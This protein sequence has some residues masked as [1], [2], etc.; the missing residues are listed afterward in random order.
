[1][2]TLALLAAAGVASTAT[3]QTLTIDI[4]ADNTQVTGA[5]DT[6]VN[7]DVVVSLSGLADANFGAFADLAFDVALADAGYTFTSFGW[8][9]TAV[10]NGFG[11]SFNL[12][13]TA[14]DGSGITGASA[15]NSPPPGNFTGGP[16]AALSITAY[17]FSIDVT[18][19]SAR[20]FSTGFALSGQTTTAF[21][22]PPFPGIQDWNAS[23]EVIVNDATIEVVPAPAS[24]G[25]L[26]LGGLVAAR[27]RR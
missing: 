22:S 5:G 24:A 25:L 1:M 3:A 10:V 12:D 21:G 19:L 18:D 17:S 6:V 2:R 7:F 11:D 27:R 16:N 26:G 4:V 23:G 8:D 9:N 13:G 20:S 15:Q 14:V